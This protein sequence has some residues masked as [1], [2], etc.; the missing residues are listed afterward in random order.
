V[1]APAS[2]NEIS[3]SPRVYVALT[4]V[5]Q[6]LAF[7]GL[8]LFLVRGDWENSFL[9]VLVIGLTLIP[10]FLLRRYRIYTP[11]E[12]QLIATAFFFLSLYLSSAVDFYYHYWWWDI[13]LH[14]GSGFLLG[15][16]GFLALFLMNQTD[17][18]P[19]GIQPAFLCF[20]GVTFAVFVG[21]LWEI[22]EF[23]VDLIVPWANMQSRETGVVDTMHDLIVDALG[24]VVVALMGWAYFKRGRYS[25]IAE[26]VR[27]FV[28]K[29]PRLFRGLSKKRK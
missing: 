15:I 26:G 25:F 18:L 13:V 22:L 28:R 17:R 10:A 24:A 9:T 16:I 3:E 8:I 1:I 7:I 5:I 2:D 23:V 14:A 19:A 4:L 29:N 21:V 27:K 12:F 11:P 20:F 6:A